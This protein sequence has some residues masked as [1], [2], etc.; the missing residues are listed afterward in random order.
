MISDNE[1]LYTVVP[2]HVQSR[3]QIFGK[4][5]TKMLSVF[6]RCFILTNSSI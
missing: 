1:L 5:E 4:E 6:Q 3:R 2:T